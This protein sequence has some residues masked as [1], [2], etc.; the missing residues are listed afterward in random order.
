M[1]RVVHV[2]WTNREEGAPPP[3]EELEDKLR[4]NEIMPLEGILTV[5]E[6]RKEGAEVHVIAVGEQSF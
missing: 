3:W 5:E 4:K 2:K 6:P 1:L